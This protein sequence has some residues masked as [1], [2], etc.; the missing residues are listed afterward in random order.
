MKKIIQAPVVQRE[1]NFIQW[2][3]CYP[4]DKLTPAKAFGKFFT[5]SHV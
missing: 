1:D 5:Q 4:A 2:I 3:S